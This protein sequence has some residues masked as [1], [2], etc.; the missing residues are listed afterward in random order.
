MHDYWRG[1]KNGQMPIHHLKVLNL[2]A[3]GAIDAKQYISHSF[4]LEEINEAFAT[5]E[6]HTGMRVVIHP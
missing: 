1:K 2:I 5:A 3:S 6:G 4:K